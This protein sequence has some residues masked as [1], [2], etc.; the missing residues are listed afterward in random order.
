MTLPN[1]LERRALAGL[2]A[3][4]DRLGL[5]DQVPAMMRDLVDGHGPSNGGAILWNRAHP[6]DP[7][8]R[9]CCDPQRVKGAAYCVCWEPEYNTTQ[10]PL[11]EPGDGEMTTRPGGMCGD[12]AYRPGS[13]EMQYPLV[14]EALL[15][16]GLTGGMFF[17]HDGMRTPTLWRHPDGRSIPGAD[18][19]YDQVVDD[20]GRPYRTNGRVAFICAGFAARSSA[21]TNQYLKTLDAKE[22]DRV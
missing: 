5:G 10:Q 3:E 11:T 20:L 21:L 18:G 4:A 9:D 1:E 8:P 7:T 13:D 22:P 17:C 16:L 15:D 2:V 19:D 6:D 14:R 12:C